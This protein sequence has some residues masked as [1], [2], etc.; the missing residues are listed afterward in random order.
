[1]LLRAAQMIGDDVVEPARP[2]PVFGSYG[3]L[4]RAASYRPWTTAGVTRTTSAEST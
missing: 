4:R 1:M 2:L 3:R